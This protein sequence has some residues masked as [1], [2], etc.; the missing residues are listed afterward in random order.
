MVKYRTTD[1]VGSF[2]FQKLLHQLE[3]NWNVETFIHFHVN[4]ECNRNM[5][6]NFGHDLHRKICVQKQLLCGLFFVSY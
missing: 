3:L 5:R 2:S 1:L 6:T 4:T